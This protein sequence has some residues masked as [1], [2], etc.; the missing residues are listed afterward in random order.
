[1]QCL[2]G[3]L[4]SPSLQTAPIFVVLIRLKQLVLFGLMEVTFR[5]FQRIPVQIT[6]LLAKLTWMRS[7]KVLIQ[8]TV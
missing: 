5:L 7:P 4:L 8:K 2:Q 6:S 1:M 3:L